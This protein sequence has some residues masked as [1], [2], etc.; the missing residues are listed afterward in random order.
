MT[1][2]DKVDREIK[3]AQQVLYKLY[4]KRRLIKHKIK[5][6]EMK[7]N[8][9]LS[10]RSHNALHNLFDKSDFTPAEVSKLTYG[11]LIRCPNLGNV[12]VQEIRMWLNLRKLDLKDIAKEQG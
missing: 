10:A 1:D 7:K 12:S 2:L 6:K 9:Q 3:K 11:D 5:Y 4:Q 8:D